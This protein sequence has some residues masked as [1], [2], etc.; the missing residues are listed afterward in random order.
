MAL[1]T[2]HLRSTSCTASL[3]LRADL[4]RA[5]AEAETRVCQWLVRAF[6]SLLSPGLFDET[7]GL[8]LQ[9]V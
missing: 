9:P 2:T 5:Q 6:C 3:R 4:L 7:L 1:K 8:S